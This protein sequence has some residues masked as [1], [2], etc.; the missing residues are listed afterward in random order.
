M[1]SVLFDQKHRSST[2]EHALQARL[3]GALVTTERGGP[4]LSSCGD[5]TK[6][7]MVRNFSRRR[8]CSAPL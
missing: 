4:L 7:Y 3:R 5:E 1:A 6:A 8:L 2:A